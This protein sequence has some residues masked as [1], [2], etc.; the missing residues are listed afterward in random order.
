MFGNTGLSGCNKQ[1]LYN[2]WGTILMEEYG[3]FGDAECDRCS[4]AQINFNKP[5]LSENRASGMVSRIDVMIDTTGLPNGTVLG[6]LKAS[7]VTPFEPVRFTPVVARPSTAQAASGNLSSTGNWNAS[8]TL[9]TGSKTEQWVGGRG[10][11]VHADVRSHAEWQLR[12]P[13]R[14]PKHQ[15]R[16]HSHRRQN[17]MRRGDVPAQ[18]DAAHG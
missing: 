18:R 17:C 15:R 11:D 12:V 10:R 3:D 16:L 4:S 1:A 7:P 8:F 2:K 9:V 5:L 13:C 6:E 14:L